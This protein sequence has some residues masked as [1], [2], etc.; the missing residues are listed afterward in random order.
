MGR[1]SHLQKTDWRLA[2]FVALAAVLS[3]VCAPCFQPVYSASEDAP[4]VLATILSVLAGFLIAVMAIVADDRSLR[5]K[6]W[7]QDT[8]YLKSIRLQL[9]RHKFMFHLYL[10]VLVLIFICSMGL[11]WPSGVQLWAERVMLGLATFA[12]LLSFALPSEL[13]GRQ[14]ANLVSQ[15]NER[16]DRETGLEPK[17]KEPDDKT[18]VKDD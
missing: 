3:I 15:I 7:K 18:P 10:V 12:L 6:T 16:R 4:T 2:R 8:Y 17:R 13:T 1:L 14:L 9:K 11:H 5:G